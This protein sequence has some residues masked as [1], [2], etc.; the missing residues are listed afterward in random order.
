MKVSPFR[1]LFRSGGLL[2][3]GL[4]IVST[5]R[6]GNVPDDVATGQTL[7][8]NTCGG[9]HSVETNRIGPRHR[10][11][12][13]RAVARVPGYDYSPALKKLGG[14]WTPARLDQWLSGTQKM[15]PGSKM[16]LEL[17]DPDVRRSIIT[18][19]Q[20]VSLPAPKY[21]RTASPSRHWRKRQ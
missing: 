4:L 8:L 19:L 2:L 20:S 14:T 3:A 12:V 15:A 10:N 13:G 7:Y 1:A 5:A 21:S 17:D 9:C 18:Y 16:Y 11:V 6:A